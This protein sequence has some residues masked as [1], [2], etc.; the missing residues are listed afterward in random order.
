MRLR[1]ARRDSADDPTLHQVWLEAVQAAQ[2]AY[3]RWATALA[4]RVRGHRGPALR[5]KK[6]AKAR[7]SVLRCHRDEDLRDRQHTG[8]LRHFI[9]CAPTPAADVEIRKVAVAFSSFSRP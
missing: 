2:Q 9:E 4:A 6:A 3:Q 7:R 8:R 1:R 5:R